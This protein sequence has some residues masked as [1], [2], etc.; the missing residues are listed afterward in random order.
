MITR[1]IFLAV[2]LC[3]ILTPLVARGE[4]AA[5][6]PLRILFIGNSYTAYNGGLYK[7]LPIMAQA[8]GRKLV[9][10]YTVAGGK[11]LEWHFKEGAAL[12]KIREG[13]WD[14]VVLQDYS[15][16]ALKKRDLMFEYIRKLDAEIDKVGAKTVLYMTWARQDKPQNQQTITQAHESAASDVGAIIVPAGNIWQASLN[17]KP[18]FA[19]HRSD[20]SHP[21]A[22][23]TYLVACAFYATLV[24]DSP[25]GLP[26]PTIKEEGLEAR[27]LTADET[28]YLQKTA[29]DY[30]CTYHPVPATQPA[31]QPVSTPK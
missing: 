15:L 6:K 11:S 5:D 14:Y 2:V 17:Q 27:T 16:Q 28:A 3:S 9:C 21:N 31:T 24:K 30:V 4:D 20:K 26:A 10:D 19:L 25:V 8:R 29:A 12:E 18:D 22:A 23:G 13:N 7:L 1:R